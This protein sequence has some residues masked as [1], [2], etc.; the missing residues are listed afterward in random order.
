MN[1]QNFKRQHRHALCI[2]H[3]AMLLLLASC[4]SSPDNLQ[5]VDALPQIYPDYTGV[6]IPVNIAPME[7]AMQSD[8]Y[9]RVSV[10]FKAKDGTEYEAT[11]DNAVN[12]DADEW[13]SLLEKTQGDSLMVTVRAHNS[14]ASNGE[15]RW[16]AF[17]SFPMYVVSDSIDYSI[18]YRLIAPGYQTYS[19]M[20]VYQ[21]E[22]ST[23]N[24]TSNYLNTEITNACV[25]CHTTCK[26]DPN[27]QSLH[28]RGKKGGTVLVRNGKMTTYSTKIPDVTVGSAVY[29]YWHPSG[30]FIAYSTN[31]IHQ[32]FYTTPTDLMDT[33]DLDSDVYIYDIEKNQISRSEALMDTA[34]FET[35]PAFSPDGKTMY[36]CRAARKQLPADIKDVHYDLC[37]VSFDPQTGTIGSKVDTVVCASCDSMSVSMPRPSNDGRYLIYCKDNYGGIPVTHHESDLWILDLQ[38]GESRC[39][40]EV[41]SPD[42]ADAFHNWSSNDRWMVFGSRRED[43]THTRPYFT[44]IDKNGIGRKPF[45]L[46]Q[47]D[48]KNYYAELM[49]SYNCLEFVKGP[50]NFDAKSAT[51]KLV[52]DENIQFK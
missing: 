13:R 7:F 19:K 18:I 40:T 2:M 10:I 11:G 26:G 44:Y 16:E 35:N 33:Y 34:Y 48:P 8:D 28:I 5:Q 52:D 51:S 45:L 43:G 36:F 37:K 27:T 6:T 24:E 50:C 38:T 30:N 17:R 15:G 22:L 32:S 1:L 20:G 47:H 39:M 46:P 14:S 42:Y 21:R 23:T 4:A 31:N 3:F 9:D 49:L 29:P 25:N 41:N 12:I